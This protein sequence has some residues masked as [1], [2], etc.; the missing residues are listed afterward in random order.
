M[1]LTP[2]QQRFVDEYLIDNNA[3]QAAKRAGYSEKTAHVIGG[4]NLKKPAIAAAI[5]EALEAQQE[6]TQITADRVLKELARIATS[7]V[8]KLLTDGE[9]LRPVSTL[10]DDTAAAIASVEI[11]AKPGEVDED[12]NR[13]IEHVHKIKMWDKNTALTQLGRHFKMF[14]DRIEGD[15]TLSDRI[16]DARSRTGR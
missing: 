3:T 1:A 13:T 8:R 10:D 16:A 15:V 7:D 4:E 5:S 9:S 2:K 6:R 12:G 14:T 11:V